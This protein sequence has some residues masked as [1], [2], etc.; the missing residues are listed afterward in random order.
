MGKDKQEKQKSKD[1]KDKSKSKDKDSAAN[2][3][4]SSSTAASSSSAPAKPW[5]VLI[6]DSDDKDWYAM[7]EGKTTA[8]GRKI[9]IER[10][11]L[12]ATG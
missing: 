7:F 5:N 8:S 12:C 11:R 6:I 3:K 9:V 1:K 10:V 4:S 2:N